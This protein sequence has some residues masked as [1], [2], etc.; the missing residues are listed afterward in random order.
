[1]D[2]A[3]A[4]EA[5]A[6]AAAEL[7]GDHAP[8]VRRLAAA[9]D[10][11]RDLDA[12]AAADAALRARVLADLAD[13]DGRIAAATAEGLGPGQVAG[14]RVVLERLAQG[15]PALAAERELYRADRAAWTAEVEAHAAT[16]AELAPLAARARAAAEAAEAAE[17]ALAEAGG[18]L[19]RVTRALERVREAQAAVGEARDRA[20]R[21]AE[22][23]ASAGAHLAEADAAMAAARAA[24]EEAVARRR[25]AEQRDAALHAAEGHGPGDPCP[26][27]RRKL[28]AGFT[29]P[30]ASDLEAGRAVEGVAEAAR[31]SAEAGHA[32]CAERLVAAGQESG[33]AADAVSGAEEV[34][35]A[36][37]ADLRALLPGADAGLSDGDLLA[38]VRAAHGDLGAAVAQRRADRAA[39]EAAHAERSAALSAARARLKEHGSELARVAERLD[40]LSAELDRSRAGLPASVRPAVDGVAE[41][42]DRLGEHERGLEA[43]TAERATLADELSRLDRAEVARAARRR[44]EVDGPREAA[45][46]RLDALLA[47]CRRAAE[48]LGRPAPEQP[49]ETPEEAGRLVALAAELAEALAARRDDAARAVAEA[50]ARA[51]AALR[52]ARMPDAAALAAARDLAAA[53]ALSARRA[54]DTAAAAVPAAAELDADIVPG[55]QMVEDLRALERSL[56]DG[57]FPRYAIGLRQAALLAVA[58]EILGDMTG[59]RFGFSHRFEIVD[60]PAGRRRSPRTLSGGETFLASLALSLALVELTGRAGG[61][62]ECLFLDEGFGALDPGA[63]D[64]ALSELERRAAGGRLVGVISHVPAVAERIESVLH[65]TND[66]ATGS[67]VRLLDGAERERLLEGAAASLLAE[68][69]PA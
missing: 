53:E 6:R 44:E 43:L 47:A 27:C 42:L 52:D 14:V 9:R 8:E 5:A 12:E 20:R 13:R 59:D 18:L 46:R 31:A 7:G 21:A 25:D 66:P 61:L 26:V 63:L 4:A 10:A 2:E 28:P 45:R 1:V 22:G 62:V 64:Q 69:V 51:A 60:V 17:R 54:R 24:A 35:G 48:A 19:Q 56:T 3:A 30:D 38:P 29:A 55:R 41:A 58:T 16:A 68:A 34:L 67:H 37:L 65:V 36:R 33:A 39:A 57:A 15:V 32:R 40:G 11:E 23:L 49:D 50:Q